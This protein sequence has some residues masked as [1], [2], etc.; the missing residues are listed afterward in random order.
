MA[1]CFS[2]LQQLCDVPEVCQVIAPTLLGNDVYPILSNGFRL[3]K[4]EVMQP[5]RVLLRQVEQYL[6]PLQVISDAVIDKKWPGGVG[7][8]NGLDELSIVVVDRFVVQQ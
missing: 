8:G 4:A 1:S 3:Q 6:Q 7:I 5:S 2:T